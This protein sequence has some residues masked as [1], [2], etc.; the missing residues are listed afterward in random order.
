MRAG[1]WASGAR[2]GHRAGDRGSAA[3]A[4]HRAPTS[5]PRVSTQDGLLAELPRPAGPVLFAAAEGART[6]IVDELGADF[7]PLYRT[8][9]L[10]PTPP[11]GDVVVLASASAARAFGALGAGIPAVS[12]GPQTTAAARAV[13]H[14]RGR[15]GASGTISTGS[16]TRSLG[17]DG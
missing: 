13:G 2:R 17:S 15:G 1:A 10:R 16:S 14:P 6:L 12:I 8:T 9:E 4:R 3:R 5:C 7:V 11:A